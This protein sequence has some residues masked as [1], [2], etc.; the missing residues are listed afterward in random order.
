VEVAPGAGRW[1]GGGIMLRGST[2]LLLSPLE[3][4]QQGDRRILLKTHPKC[5]PIDILS[6]LTH[7]VFL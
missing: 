5:S 3:F 6:K 2:S 4:S 1:F 7:S